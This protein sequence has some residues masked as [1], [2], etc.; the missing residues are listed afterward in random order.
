[1]PYMSGKTMIQEAWNNGYAIGAFT[2]H[3][4]E[5]I[6]AVLLAAEK[7]QSPIMLQIRPK[8]D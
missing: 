4:L 2:A 8:S 6:K 1:M 5:T 3:N 7:E